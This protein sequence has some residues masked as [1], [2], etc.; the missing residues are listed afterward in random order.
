MNTTAMLLTLIVAAEH[1]YIAWLEMAKIPSPQAA[2]IFNMPQEFM[3]QKRVRVMFS[4]QGLYNAFLAIGLLWAQ[5]AAPDNAVS[6][7]T[8]LFLGFVIAAAVWGTL[9]SGNRGIILKQGLPAVLAAAA[10]LCL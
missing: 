5:F 4:N 2:R 8:L 7:A 1:F 3:A 9:S 10:V 6:G